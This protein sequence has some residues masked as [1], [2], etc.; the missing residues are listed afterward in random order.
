[1]NHIRH[2]TTEGERW[3]SIAW[4]YYGDAHAYERIIQANPGVAITPVL[5]G[6]LTLAIPI[7]EQDDVADSEEL[8]P[9]KR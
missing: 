4:R 1:M 2:L 3:D 6:G 7:V 5:P 9:W 8:P